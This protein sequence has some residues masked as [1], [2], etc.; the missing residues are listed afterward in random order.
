MHMELEDSDGHTTHLQQ[1]EAT[2]QAS[3]TTPPTSRVTIYQTGFTLVMVPLSVRDDMPMAYGSQTECKSSEYILQI[4]SLA[5]PKFGAQRLNL[6]SPPAKKWTEHGES[7]DNEVSPDA[8]PRTRS[9]LN[10]IAASHR[11]GVG[12]LLLH[13]QY[14]QP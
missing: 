3:T 2:A 8:S 11:A 9:I 12:A 4:S 13:Q 5:H 7:Q 6:E 14:Q 10:G 1:E